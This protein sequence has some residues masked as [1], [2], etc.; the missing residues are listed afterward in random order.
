MAKVIFLNRYFFPDLSATSQILSELAF[1]LAAKGHDVHVITSRQL[2]DQPEMQLPPEEAARGVKIHRFRTTAFG[3]AKLLGRSFDYLSFYL[4][5]RRALASLAAADD[6][7]VAMTDPPLL[8][9]A[10]L[11]VVKRRRARLINWLQD[12]YPEVA[13]ASGIR[14]L[15]GPVGG[16]LSLLRDRSLTT[17]QANVVV[18]QRMAERLASRRIPRGTIHF[19]PNYSIDDRISPIAAADNPLRKAW[20]L[21]EKFVVGY[22]GNLGR[23]HE[24]Q[25]ILGAAARLK[26]N[27]RIVFLC[28]G[29]G[30]LF[31]PLVRSVGKRG[32]QD[33]FVFHPYQDRELLPYSLSAPDLHWVSLRPEFEGLVVPSKVYGIAAAGRPI[34]AIGAKH[35]E[36]A[37]LVEGYRCGVVIEP[38]DSRALAESITALMDDPA[39]CAQMGKRARAMLDENFTR[40]HIFG[41]WS[42]LISKA[43]IRDAEKGMR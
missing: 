21:A 10:I 15:R 36:I 43:G 2:Y 39:L 13:M 41:L 5:A 33:K 9:L 29:G 25:T 34:V 1:A 38:G 17:A 28:I 32:L 37:S 35:G 3:R 40:S 27:P 6:I 11:S 12:L 26:G 8:S 24:F 18:G 19:I 14:W 31:E 7:V 4:A 30:R 22:S 16:A 20:G 23:V 42:E